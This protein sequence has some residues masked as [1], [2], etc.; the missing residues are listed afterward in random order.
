[1]RRLKLKTVWRCT[2]VGCAVKTA[3]T[4]VLSS[5]CCTALPLTF[6]ALSLRTVSVRL[7]SALLCPASSWIWRRRSWCTS[8]AM[9]RI[10]ANRPQA[11]VKSWVCCSSNCGN[12]FSIKAALSSEVDNNLTVST[13]KG[14]ASSCSRLNRDCFKNSAS[15]A[16]AASLG[17]FKICS[18]MIFLLFKC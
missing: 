14:D 13:T 17:L 2:S 8:S 3:V 7:P 5:C 6:P 10:C 11:R 1:M 4:T 15:A 18:C 9:F 16:K 12:T